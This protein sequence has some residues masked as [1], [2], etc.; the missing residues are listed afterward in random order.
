MR[1]RRTGSKLVMRMAPEPRRCSNWRTRLTLTTEFHM[2]RP[3]RSHMASEFSL[4][5]RRRDILR[6]E[7]ETA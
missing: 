1:G 5:A 3:K 2:G 4:A 6:E 7:K